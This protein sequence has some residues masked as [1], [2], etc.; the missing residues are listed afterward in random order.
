MD[1]QIPE[2]RGPR[3]K[4]DFNLSVGDRRSYRF[5]TTASLL[6]SAKHYCRKHGFD[7]SFRCWTLDG[8]VH[9]VRVK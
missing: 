2:T 6:N 8:M 9:I 1:F 4:F 3:S 5:T 7:W